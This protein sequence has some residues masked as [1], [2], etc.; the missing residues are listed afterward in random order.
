MTVFFAMTQF[1]KSILKIVKMYMVKFNLT[2][3]DELKI[4]EFSKTKDK[5]I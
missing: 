3:F 5:Y 1:L 2:I 4:I